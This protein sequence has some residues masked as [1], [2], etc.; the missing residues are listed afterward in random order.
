MAKKTKVIKWS[1]KSLITD[2][3]EH[4]FYCGRTPVYPHH[5]FNASCRGYSNEDDLVAPLCWDCHRKLH[6]EH[7]QR[8]MYS[9]KQ[10]GQCA[11][12]ER[13]GHDAFMKRYG[14][15]YL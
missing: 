15:N 8:M 13:Y 6:T 3:V 9:L 12:E 5:I 10:L 11:Y 14:K 2:D 1:G 4:C 7:S